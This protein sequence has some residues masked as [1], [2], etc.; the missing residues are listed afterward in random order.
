MNHRRSILLVA[1]AVAALVGLAATGQAQERVQG[2]VLQ[3]ASSLIGFANAED[4]LVEEVDERPAKER[5]AAEGVSLRGP[6]TV[7]APGEEAGERVYLLGL[8]A[9]SALGIDEAVLARYAN[10]NLE[11]A[12]L[13]LTYEGGCSSPNGKLTVHAIETPS[14]SPFDVAWDDTTLADNGS[15]EVKGPVLASATITPNTVQDNAHLGCNQATLAVKTEPVRRIFEAELGGI[16]MTWDGEQELTVTTLDASSPPRLEVNVTTNG[17]EVHDVS[18][19]DGF[20]AVVDTGERFT[21]TANATDPQGLPDDGVAIDVQPENATVNQASTLETTRSGDL[22]VA[23]KTFPADAEG[24]YTLAA[25]ATDGDGWQ[26]RSGPNASTP[27]VVA[28]GTAPQVPLTRLAD[29]E[30]G[31]LVQVDEGQTLELVANV[32]DL[33]CSSGVSPCGEWRLE[34]RE[35]TLANGTL[36]S[37]ERIETEVPLLR[38]GNTTARLVVEDLVGHANRS[39]TW[40]LAV[41]DTVQPTATPLEGTDLAPGQ[42]VTLENGTAVQLHAQVEDD[43]PVDARL[44]MEGAQAIERALDV[45]EEGRIEAELAGIPEGFYQ[46]RLVLDDGTYSRPVGFGDLTIAPR[47]APSVSIDLPSTRVGADEAIEATVRD[48]DLDEAQTTVVAE[49]NGLEVQPEVSRQAVDDGQDLTIH[50]GDVSHD[51]VVNLT[52]RAQ[53]EQGLD[54]SARAQFTVDAEAPRLVQPDGEAW[55]APGET[56]RFEA[57]DAGGGDVTVT[58]DAANARSAGPSPRLVNADKL[59]SGSGRLVNVTVTLSDDLGNE[60]TTSV[61]VGVDETPPE[62]TPEFTRE[63]LTLVTADEASGVLRADARVGVNGAEVNET[64]V[65]QESPTRFFVATGELTRGDEVRLVAQ[66]RDHV[67]HETTLGTPEDPLVLTVPDRAPSIEIERASDTV[68]TVGRVNWT[69][70]DPDDDPLDVTVHVTGPTG[71]TEQVSG[72]AIGSH[73]IEPDQAGRYSVAVEARSAG[74]TTE[75]STFFYLSPEGRLTEATSVPDSVEPG[76]PLVVELS[77]PHEPLRVFVTAVDEDEAATSADVDLQG[78]RATATFDELPEGT[79][80]VQA[81]VVHEEG[82]SETVHLASVQSQQPLGDRL[83]DL[84]VPLLVLLA[85]ALVVA[86]VAVWYRRRQE[87][88]EE[89]EAGPGPAAET[90]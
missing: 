8:S 72:N 20:P 25:E 12:Y 44:L 48:R 63:G 87:E 1:L 34:W 14:W 56:L 85:I 29:H 51:D 33:T 84:V 11:H 82:A 6:S 24:R 74:N 88:D 54:A 17:P 15:I 39:A 68:G 3:N 47:G 32:S 50:L 77:F 76:R 18:V 67:G 90:P 30:P 5:A 43:L 22:F 53:D 70:E 38:P 73:A 28:D 71:E 58:L 65:F 10:G 9:S 45:D 62:A 26:A 46:V 27:H 7:S 36:T 42:G 21:V 75:A 19:A 64:Q 41:A 31:Q 37:D 81:T 61:R 80:D 13:H 49:V 59:V 23:S 35:E 83:G 57:T 86:I 66:V 52:V 16:A 78:S 89:A 40:T 69:A 55:A 2:D 79:Y 4:T 60:R